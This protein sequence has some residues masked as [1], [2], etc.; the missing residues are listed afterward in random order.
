MPGGL[1]DCEAQPAQEARW[2]IGEP[3]GTHRGSGR[4]PPRRATRGRWW[5][6]ASCAVSTTQTIGPT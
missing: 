5:A 2:R 1:P 4:P 3:S 6:T